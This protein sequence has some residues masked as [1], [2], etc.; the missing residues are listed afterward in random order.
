M[1]CRIYIMPTSGLDPESP[2]WQSFAS[3]ERR[4]TL[5][6]ISGPEGK[7]LSLAAELALCAAALDRGLSVPPVYVRGGNGKPA[8]PCPPPYFSLSHC[9]GAAL[10]AVSDADVGADAERTDRTV[11]AGVLR[12]ILAPGES[13]AVPV[14]KWVA[15]ESYLKLTGEGLR[16]DM[17]SFSE[18]GEGI[19]TLSG[20]KLAF[21]KTLE[22][23]GLCIAVSSYIEITLSVTRIDAEELAA[24][25]SKAALHRP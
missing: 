1:N 20:E 25:L 23:E 15:K 14:R 9:S 24:G 13:A 17:R 10:C 4:S 11:S 22:A 16:R 8:F 12:R 19:F 5:S 7:Q 21:T 3:P 18:N 6:R 2:L